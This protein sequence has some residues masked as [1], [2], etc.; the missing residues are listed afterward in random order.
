MEGVGKQCIITS[1]I[2]FIDT[3]SIPNRYLYYAF[4]LLS[5]IKPSANLN[6]CK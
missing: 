1:E 5:F 6:Q 4:V 3:V 2:D